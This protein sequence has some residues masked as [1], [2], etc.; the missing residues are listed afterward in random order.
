M[1]VAIVHY[2]VACTCVHHLYKAGFIVMYHVDRQTH[3][4]YILLC[5]AASTNPATHQCV[6]TLLGVP[7]SAV[8]GWVGGLGV[9]VRTGV[10]CCLPFTK[11][12]PALRALDKLPLPSC[13]AV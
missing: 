5:F 2:T 6:C 4:C 8:G 10:V 9:V 3:V 13:I 1:Y 11:S 7:A 12:K